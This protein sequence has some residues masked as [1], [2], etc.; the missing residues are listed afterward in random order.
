MLIYMIKTASN[1]VFNQHVLPYDLKD[2][3]ET[4]HRRAKLYRL[5][6]RRRMHMISFIF[7]YTSKQ[8][9]LYIRDI[10][11]RRR[12]GILFSIDVMENYKARQD[13]MY[14]AMNAWNSLPVAIRNADTKAHLNALLRNS[15][16][17]PYSKV[18]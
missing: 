4:I 12:D 14:R 16:I 15:I 7:N 8:E 5:A 9:L 2:S 1:I 10:N 6:H 13:P 3:T 18:E 11:T 17:N